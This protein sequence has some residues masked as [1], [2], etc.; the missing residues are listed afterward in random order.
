MEK[1]FDMNRIFLIVGLVLIGFSC[2]SQTN[3]ADDKAGMLVLQ[4][5]DYTENPVDI[6]NPDRGFYRP[7]EYVV[8]VDGKEKPDFPELGS[9]ITGT[10]VFVNA[11]I[12]YMSFDLQNFS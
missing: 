11:R 5:L 1:I 12:V 4:E 9:T 7:Q 3:G 8:P 2:A 6:P 10:T